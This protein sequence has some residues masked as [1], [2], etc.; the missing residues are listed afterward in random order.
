MWYIHLNVSWDCGDRLD[1]ICHT[2]AAQ[3]PGKRSSH[4]ETLKLEALWG[5][6]VI[7]A[8]RRMINWSFLLT[9]RSSRSENNKC[10]EGHTVQIYLM[11]LKSAYEELQW[12]FTCV[13]SSDYHFPQRKKR[14]VGIVTMHWSAN[15]KLNALITESKKINYNYYNNTQ[16]SVHSFIFSSPK[17]PVYIWCR[18]VQW[19]K[20]RNIKFVFQ[21]WSVYIFFYAKIFYPIP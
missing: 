21:R 2:A 15:L 10:G 11:D 12:N 5:T 13:K 1:I 14:G 17:S 20:R 6:R 9:C 18:H 3:R 4:V 16:C 8:R 19:S 7:S